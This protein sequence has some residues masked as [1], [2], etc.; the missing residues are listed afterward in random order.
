MSDCK[1]VRALIEDLLAGQLDPDRR[2]QLD[3][4]LAQCDSCRSLVEMHEQLDQLAEPAPVPSRSEFRRMRAELLAMTGEA[5]RK[6]P[7]ALP[8]Q[9]RWWMVGASLATAATLMVGIVVGR[10]TVSEATLDERLLLNSVVAQA[11]A[12]D[13]LGDLWS[14]PLSYAN[15][16]T[17]ALRNGQLQVDFDVCSRLDVTTPIDS[18]L[19]LELL[20]HAVVDARSVGER[21]RAIEIA[22]ASSDPRLVEALAVTVEND[23]N[24]AVRIEAMNALA[25]KAESPRTRAALF[26]VLRADDSVQIRLMALEQLA[27]QKVGFDQLREVIAAGE[28]ESDGAVLQR[29]YQL[30]SDEQSP[31]W[32]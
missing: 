15:V 16:S 14:R 3:Q 20:S 10:I 5:A 2:R 7:T 12:S 1:D 23:P 21:L 18:N 13:E 32:L 9:Q 17:G 6:T 28:Q 30:R 19:A 25:S 4:H 22:A 24:L 29:A 8:V 27:A 11:N 31:D 26:E